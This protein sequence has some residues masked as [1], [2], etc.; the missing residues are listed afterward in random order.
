MRD[1]PDFMVLVGDRSLLEA[2]QAS[3]LETKTRGSSSIRIR[4]SL[5]GNTDAGVHRSRK[6]AKAAD[7]SAYEYIT[8][9]KT[10]AVGGL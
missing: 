4:A 8:R 7:R 9:P 5:Q 2:Q 10:A 3:P 1:V 6:T